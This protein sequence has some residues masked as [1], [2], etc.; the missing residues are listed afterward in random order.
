MRIKFQ[1]SRWARKILN[2]MRKDVKH[3]GPENKFSEKRRKASVLKN[4]N[5]LRDILLFTIYKMDIGRKD[6]RTMYKFSGSRGYFINC[7]KRGD[8]TMGKTANLFYVGDYFDKID[9]SEFPEGW[10]IDMC[11]YQPLEN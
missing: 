7:S 11:V 5:V 10:N 6:D 9:P 8:R 4:E 3:V 2:F 1:V